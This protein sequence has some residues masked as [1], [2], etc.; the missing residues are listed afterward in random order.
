MEMVFLHGDLMGFLNSW[1]P[2]M[3]NAIGSIIGP[4][5][6][7]RICLGL[8]QKNRGAAGRFCRK[9]A[10]CLSALGSV[11]PMRVCMAKIHRSA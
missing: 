8:S 6:M 1:Q 3:I 9:L 2:E 5:W 11:K 4:F 7:K 10:D